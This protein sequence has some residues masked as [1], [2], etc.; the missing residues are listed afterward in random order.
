MIDAHFMNNYSSINAYLLPHLKNIII[1]SLIKAREDFC[2]IF[3]GSRFFVDVSCQN[4]HLIDTFSVR[5]SLWRQQ[6]DD[7][8]LNI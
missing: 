3:I 1:G 4:R 6:E 5:A 8:S 7:D 2:A